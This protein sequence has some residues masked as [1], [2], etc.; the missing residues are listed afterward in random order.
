MSLVI[1]PRMVTAVLLA[2]GWH[3][4]DSGS[5]E[6]DDFA[7][8]YSKDNDDSPEARSAHGSGFSGTRG[9]GDGFRFVVENGEHVSGP[10]A[11]ILAVRHKLGRYRIKGILDPDT[12]TS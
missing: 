8:G 1:D 4:I 10:F 9:S 6:L 11:A 7:F 12:F 5:F 3:E 2:A